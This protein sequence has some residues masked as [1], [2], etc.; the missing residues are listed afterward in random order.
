MHCGAGKTVVAL[1][2]AALL[3]R[4]T[5]VVVHK[6][7]LMEQWEARIRAFLPDATVGSISQGVATDAAG[8]DIVLCMLQS[9]LARDDNFYDLGR[10]G[11]VIF[12]ECHQ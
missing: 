12:D 3:G 2:L 9:V 11:H 6:K 8:A 5:L 7:L 10:F 1:R 4:P